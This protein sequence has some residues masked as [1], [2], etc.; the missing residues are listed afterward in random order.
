MWAAL[1]ISMLVAPK[2]EWISLFDGKTLDGWTPK[3]AGY[4]AGDN[5]GNTFRVENGAIVVRYDAYEGGFKDRFGHLFYKTPF[6]HYRLQLEV[7][8]VGEQC[9][10]GP[11]WAWRN[12]GVMIHGQTPESMGLGQ[13]F[14]VSCE[15]QFLGGPEQGE[16]A[17]ANVCTPGTNIVMN[18]KLVT[19]HCLDSS[20]TTFRGDQ[21]VPME[22]EVHGHGKV[23]HKVKNLPVL[24]Y[25]QVQYDPTDGDAQ[26]LIRE[27][28]LK[29][30]GGTIS[31]QSESHPVEFRNIRLRQLK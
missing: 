7:R 20:S 16:R 28:N 11:G 5:F 18:G 12:S 8:F 22:I 25:E 27:G 4:R 17:T 26:K 6:S 31:L 10:G 3:I 30:E 1:A 24:S 14:P 2:E 19:Q 21:W 13:S 23:I 9:P 29:I 15:V